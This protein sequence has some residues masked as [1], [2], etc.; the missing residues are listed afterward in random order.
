MKSLK[1][2]KLDEKFKKVMNTPASFA[3]FVAIHEFIEYIE[4]D[5]VLSRHFSSKSRASE[6]ADLLYKYTHLKRIHQGLKDIKI[7]TGEDLGHV[8]L[9][10]V[11]DLNRIRNK[12]TKD[13]NLFWEKRESFRKQA[14]EIYERLNATL[15]TKEEKLKDESLAATVN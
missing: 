10:T 6:N 11:R 9:T 2:D 12:E 15:L 7:K 1:K 13:S 14:T 8:R 4:R 5:R 3:F